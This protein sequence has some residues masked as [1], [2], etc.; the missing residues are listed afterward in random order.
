MCI[1]IVLLVAEFIYLKYSYMQIYCTHVL[2]LEYIYIH[3]F[4]MQVHTYIG[5]TNANEP[6]IQHKIKIFFQPRFYSL[7]IFTIANNHSND[8]H[9]LLL[10][11]FWIMHPTTQLDAL[12]KREKYLEL[13]W[14]MI[15]STDIKESLTNEMFGF[16]RVIFKQ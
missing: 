6:T 12:S 1:F 14:N 4:I 3:L 8:G 9:L 7:F 13:K 5:T 10:Y 16:I 2:S 11:L 15:Y